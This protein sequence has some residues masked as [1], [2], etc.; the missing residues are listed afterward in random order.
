MPDS[1]PPTEELALFHDGGAGSFRVWDGRQSGVYNAAGNWFRLQ[2]FDPNQERPLPALLWELLPAFHSWPLRSGAQPPD[3][4]T[5]IEQECDPVAE[6]EI[7]G[8][9]AQYLRCESS[10]GFFDLWLDAETNLILKL[11]NPIEALTLE[12]TSIE[13][14]PAFPPDIF[15][16]APPA[17]A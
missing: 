6:A 16:F 9:R 1:L 4:L 14:D 8:R 12:V 2:E 17:G 3:A 5:Y 15:Q 13:Y 10:G 7:A 11:V